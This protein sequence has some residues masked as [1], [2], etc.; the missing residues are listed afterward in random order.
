MNVFASKN[1]VIQCYQD[2]LDDS[3]GLF[4]EEQK[5]TLREAKTKLEQ[6]QFS[7]V[8]AG[9]FSSGKSLWINRCFL[10][11]DVLPS[12]NKPTTCHPVQIVYGET[13]QLTL[14]NRMGHT[15]T[16]PDSGQNISEA[17]TRYGAQ[18]GGDPDRFEHL[19]LHWNDPEILK[20]GLVIV[21]T[22]GTEDIDDRYIH[23]THLEMSKSSAVLFVF[24][25]QQA[26]AETEWDFLERHM[27][28]SGKRLFVVINKSDTLNTDAD[29]EMVL[30]DLRERLTSFFGKRGVRV[31]ERVFMVSAKTGDGLD[32]L[33]QR[34]VNFIARER[35]DDLVRQHVRELGRALE[36][37]CQRKQK[38]LQDLENRKNSEDQKLREAQQKVANLEEDLESRSKEILDLE[39]DLVEEATKL[40]EQD[41]KDL[42]MYKRQIRESQREVLPD[43]IKEVVDKLTTYS[44]KVGQQLQR[45]I[46]KA[47]DT[48]VSSWG[49][50]IELDRFEMN[51]ETTEGRDIAYQGGKVT[52][53]TAMLGGAGVAAYGVSQGIAA[54]ITVATAPT[55]GLLGS[56]WGALVGSTSTSAGAAA[57]VAGGPLIV[58]GIG[59]ALMG[60]AVYN[61]ME[62]MG[63]QHDREKALIFLDEML[64]ETKSSVSKSIK[65]YTCHAI[66]N[67]ME[68][69][70]NQ[71]KR[72]KQRLAAIIAE[73]NEI[74]LQAQIV[75]TH[76][77]LDILKTHQI[78]LQSL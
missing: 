38:H 8:V 42:Q 53:A 35:I 31:D 23:K 11:S 44:E 74:V 24:N 56:L 52:G 32:E 43:I 67:Y 3:N 49:H 15:E 33:R 63:L 34:L 69:Y 62:K 14:C 9:R 57:A 55:P 66:T 73:Q 6:E 54:A 51:F 26:G 68:Q 59:I 22:I 19:I 17:L 40:F 37:T 48:K 61:V 18:Y 41:I 78:Q 4:I 36:S 16:I 30:D 10:R 58:G 2:L 72:E 77:R 39:D 28:E 7:I 70:Q 60:Y 75:K 12:T 29:R 64:N 21:D 47:V 20:N 50:Q 5:T 1:K 13:N 71:I 46:R 45:E 25:A 76:S 27:A 65:N